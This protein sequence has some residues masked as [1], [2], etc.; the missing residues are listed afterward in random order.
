MREENYHVATEPAAGRLRRISWGAII[1]GVAV[2]LL[3]QIMLTLLGVSIGAAT[4][5]PQDQAP[6]QGLALGSGIWLLASVLISVWVG[7]CVAGWLCNGTRRADGLLHGVV[8]WSVAVLLILFVFSNAAGALIGGTRS[9]MESAMGNQ[10][11]TQNFA[12]EL[13]GM[14][15]GE[16]RGGTAEGMIDAQTGAQVATG[17]AQGA[18]WAFLSLLLGLGAAA[19]GG[20]LGTSSLQ[21]HRLARHAPT[22]TEPGP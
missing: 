16:A 17:V 10:Q 21:Q 2:T 12:A 20:W 11:I 9:L 4:I 5:N 3:I 13:E 1:A 22:T 8:T 7:S 14:L 18:F 15:S 6:A 19:W